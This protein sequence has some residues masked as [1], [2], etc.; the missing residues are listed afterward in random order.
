MAEA[1]AMVP[2]PAGEG[3]LSA[4]IVNPAGVL[5]GAEIRRAGA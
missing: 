5:F 4:A 3:G 2:V 1:F